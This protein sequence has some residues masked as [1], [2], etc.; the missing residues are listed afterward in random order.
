MSKEPLP[1][2]ACFISQW[3][4]LLKIQILP[5]LPPLRYVF[6]MNSFSIA[7]N[8]KFPKN[9]LIYFCL[10]FVGAKFRGRWGKG[11][12]LTLNPRVFLPIDNITHPLL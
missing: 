9:Y 7:P 5:P 1:N 11:D 12:T 2:D 4:T 6:F 8:R 10:F 3:Q